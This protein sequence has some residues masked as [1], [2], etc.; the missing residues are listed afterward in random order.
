MD[1]QNPKGMPLGEPAGT[2]DIFAENA[3]LL[4]DSV[5]TGA[6]RLGS[7]KRPRQEVSRLAVDVVKEFL[8]CLVQRSR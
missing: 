5:Q 7:D 8:H 1:A 4:S 2:P 3:A 6:P